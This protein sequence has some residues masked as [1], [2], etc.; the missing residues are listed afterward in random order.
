M[1]IIFLILLTA[2]IFSK[3]FKLLGDTKYDDSLNSESTGWYNKDT[4]IKDVQTEPKQIIEI[5]S[6][7]EA[8][9]HEDERSIL[10]KI[11]E[12]DSSFK[13]EEFIK[14]AKAAFEFILES[15]NSNKLK[16]IKEYLSDDVYQIFENEVNKRSKLNQ[17]FSFTLVSI[18]NCQIVS[19][20]EKDSFVTIKVKYTSEQINVVYDKTNDFI[21]KGSK[22]NIVL[23]NDVWLFRKNIQSQSK[24]WQLVAIEE[25]TNE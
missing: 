18:K 2:Y 4:N 7:V 1:N 12:T 16:E 6:V 22:S 3:L 11:R 13:A 20:S 21:I 14:K 9:L 25:E 5:A 17:R 15:F 23:V 8:E 10:D 19:I 24:Q